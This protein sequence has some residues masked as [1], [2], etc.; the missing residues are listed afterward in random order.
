LRESTVCSCTA[1]QQNLI[2]IFFLIFNFFFFFFQISSPSGCTF[3]GK[4]PWSR[5]KKILWQ[6]GMLVGAPVGIGLVAGIALPAMTIGIICKNNVIALHYIAFY[7]RNPCVGWQKIVRP[8][9]IHE[10]AQEESNHHQ[11]CHCIC[12][13]LTLLISVLMKLN[14]YYKFCCNIL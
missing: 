10:Q 8:L 12:K 13:L 1:E 14:W 7:C 6:L 4:K 3:W 5:K 11:W 9:Q 2:N